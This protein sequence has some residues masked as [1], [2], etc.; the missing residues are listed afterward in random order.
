MTIR[1]GSKLTL[2]LAGA[3]AAAVMVAPVY[4]PPPGGGNGN[5]NGN[6]GGGGGGGD[7]GSGDTTAPAAVSDLAVIDYDF[8]WVGLQWTTTGDDGM[9]G[10]ATD[11]RVRYSTSLA[12]D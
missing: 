3:L 5:G 2:A 8:T 6:G 1:I 10:T 7:G 12:I 4:A 9:D 11:I